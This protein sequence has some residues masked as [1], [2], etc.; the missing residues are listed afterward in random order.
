MLH[1]IAAASIS[2]YQ[3]TSAIDF[4]GRF[5]PESVDFRFFVSL[6]GK[7]GSHSSGFFVRTINC[8]VLIGLGC[9]PGGGG[10]GKGGVGREKVFKV[11]VHSSVVS[12][13]QTALS[14]T[15]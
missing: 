10:R 9:L 6:L 2:P 11:K 4:L 7:H 15:D 5:C 3:R 1:L 8:D 14:C 13:F 12:K